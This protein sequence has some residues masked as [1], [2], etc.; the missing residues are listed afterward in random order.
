ME[1]WKLT[2]PGR[3]LGGMSEPQYEIFEATDGTLAVEVC[4]GNDSGANRS[5]AGGRLLLP[6]LK[7][8]AK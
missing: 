2:D 3:I 5:A 7:A 4:D 6:G 8:K 1:G